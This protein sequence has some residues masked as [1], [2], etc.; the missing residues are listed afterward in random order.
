MILMNGSNAWILDEHCTVI[1]LPR[2]KIY[3]FCD[4]TVGRPKTAVCDGVWVCVCGD[5]NA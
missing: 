1:H 3:L 2:K 5:Q 4:V